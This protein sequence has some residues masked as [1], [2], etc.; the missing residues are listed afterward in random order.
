ME[1][2]FEDGV[3]ALGFK[4]WCFCSLYWF[5][6]RVRTMA[7]LIVFDAGLRVACWWLV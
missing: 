2:E 1:D 7:G 6:A 3:T 4:L 5:L